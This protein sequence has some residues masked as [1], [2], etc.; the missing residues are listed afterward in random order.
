M[1]KKGKIEE[2]KAAVQKDKRSDEKKVEGREEEGTRRGATREVVGGEGMADVGAGSGGQ[3][4]GLHAKLPTSATETGK[5]DREDEEEP[6]GLQ[7]R[8]AKR[9]RELQARW[10]EEVQTKV[11]KEEDE[12]HLSHS[13]AGQDTIV[14]C[15]RCW[16]HK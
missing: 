16:A 7:Q 8:I 9:K 10:E 2:A 14:W 4:P 5:R 13:L 12:A 3:R 6:E 15:R 11:R 1:A